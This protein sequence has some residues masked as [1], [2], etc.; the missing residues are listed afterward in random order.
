[1]YIFRSRD[2][3]C[4]FRT[5]WLRLSLIDSFFLSFAPGRVCWL[6]CV[7][8]FGHCFDHCCLLGLLRGGLVGYN[9]LRIRIF[10]V[11]GL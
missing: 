6:V 9:F 2:D 7:L 11:L 1:M 3:F 4:G 5:L 10:L 8:V